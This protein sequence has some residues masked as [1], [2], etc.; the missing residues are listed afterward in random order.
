MKLTL[1][2]NA[3]ARVEYAGQHFVMDPYL[4]AAFSRPTYSGKSLNPGVELPCTPQQVLEGAEF[5]LISHLHSD[6]FDPAARELLAKDLPILCQPQDAGKLA[7][8]GFTSLHPV[9]D[10]LEWRG[11]TVTRV[12]G[13]HGTGK[14][15][16]DMGEVSGFIWQA[17]DEPTVYWVGDSILTDTVRDAILHY[18]PQVILTHSCGAVWGPERTLILM[19]AGQTAEVCRLAPQSTVAAIHMEAVDH[20]TVSRA[21]LRAHASAE[22][23]SPERLLIPAD[24]ETLIF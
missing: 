18:R 7:E 12:A 15:L 11:L 19:D 22:G 16:D 2:R 1:F 8:I 23:I 14:V 21:E 20:A 17:A 4:A 10:R 5:A 24:G 13:Q 9:A 6:H 3:T